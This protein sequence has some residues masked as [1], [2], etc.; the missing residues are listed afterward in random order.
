MMK[1]IVESQLG[2]VQEL[3]SVIYSHPEN[4]YKVSLQNHEMKAGANPPKLFAYIEFQADNLE[5]AVELGEKYI[6]EFFDALGVATSSRFYVLQKIGVFQ[7]ESGQHSRE[8]I[9]F[10]SIP[11]PNYPILA[12]DMNL[13][14]TIE[15]ILIAAKDSIVRRAMRWYRIASS[16]SSSDEQFQSFWFVLE[17]LAPSTAD[18]EKVSDKCPRCREP[19]YCNNCKDV[20]VHRPYPS[21]AIRQLFHKHVKDDPERAYSECSKMRHAL[22]HGEK[23]KDVEEEYKT[24]LSELVDR[25]AKVAWASLLSRVSNAKP[26]DSKVTQL[27]YLHRP[28]HVNRLLVARADV[29]IELKNEDELSIDDFPNFNMEIIPS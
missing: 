21:Q 16:A 14:S 7:W 13:G 3:K 19:L 8:G 29:S 5:R 15:S 4:T 27:L 20:P 10:N 23:I 26:S 25:L 22:L 12:L 11:D 24:T 6:V 28:T 9:V 2:V 17:T 18:R 1:F